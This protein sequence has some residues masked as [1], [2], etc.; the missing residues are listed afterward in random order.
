MLKYIRDTLVDAG[1]HHVAA[2]VVRIDQRPVEFIVAP[3]VSTAASHEIQDLA[4]EAM[5]IKDGEVGQ[6]RTDESLQSVGALFTVQCMALDA[7]LALVEG[8]AVPAVVACRASKKAHR[9]ANALTTYC[10]WSWSLDPTTTVQAN[11]YWPG[12]W[13]RMCTRTAERIRGGAKH[14]KASE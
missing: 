11:E 6:A 2:E 5:A 1:A 10:G 13:C 3:S 14:S 8:R 9:V 4:L 7:R 12:Q